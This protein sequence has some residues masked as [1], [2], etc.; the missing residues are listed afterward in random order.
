MEQTKIRLVV[1][2]LRAINSADI[3]LNGITL[4]AG[5][6]GSG[7]STLSRLLYHSYRASVHYHNLVASEFYGH[8]TNVVLLLDIALSGIYSTATKRN[9][10][11]E[12]IELEE[13]KRMVN[14][15]EFDESSPQKWIDLIN[16]VENNFNSQPDKQIKESQTN[17][18]KY[19]IREIINDKN[20]ENYNYVPFNKLVAFISE[21]GTTAL[22]LIKQRPKNLF[23]ADLF[24]IYHEP[25]TAEQFD[26][27]EL[28][29]T[30]AALNKKTVSIP[31]LVDQPIYIA[32]HTVFE[33]DLSTDESD[34]LYELLKRKGKSRHLH[35]YNQIGNDIINGNASFDES[36]KTSDDFQFRSNTG[37][38]FDLL[39]C[40]SGLKAFAVLQLLLNNGSLT[41]K[42]L[43]IIDE[44]E[45]NLHPQ[46]IIEYARIIVLLN[47]EIGVKFFIASHNPDM[48]SAIKYIAQK[49][50]T[51][52]GLN[53]YLAEKRDSDFLYDYKHLG[54]DI[55]PIFASFNIAI[56]KMNRYSVDS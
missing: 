5:E 15:R 54:T 12:F 17:R 10:K 45:S 48:V 49:E 22:E 30:I 38:V 33:N 55:E 20:I 44:P 1:K 6:N 53:F 13:L 3:E 56:D 47:K 46:W 8:V 7:K 32:T 19:I 23:F 11:E 41:D 43:L 39:D 42:T 25:V 28:G 26:F 29:E 2:K 34:D 37:K 9:T 52:S 24:S 16:K 31:Y 51:E 21:K 36:S 4:V 27:F 35:L 14:A 40:A 18:L 50:R